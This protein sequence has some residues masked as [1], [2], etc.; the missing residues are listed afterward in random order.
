VREGDLEALLAVLDPDAVLRIDAAAR[1]DGVVR[2]DAPARD[3]GTPREL[4]GASTWAAQ[5]IT[6]SRGMPMRFVQPALI[7]GA[8]GV[9]LIR[10][11]R[12]AR[13]LTF[14]FVHDRVTRVEAIGD[15]A[16]LRELDITRL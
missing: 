9:I 8:V 4:R 3:A 15:P 10:R 6:L 5:L 2:V 7:D 11:G 16:R 12:L 1:F 14:T 13:A